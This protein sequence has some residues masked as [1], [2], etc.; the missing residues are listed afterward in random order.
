MYCKQE[1]RSIAR[2][3]VKLNAKKWAQDASDDK[4]REWKEAK[5]MCIV[6]DYFFFD[7]HWNAIECERGAMQEEDEPCTWNEKKNWKKNWTEES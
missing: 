7:A 3:C 5:S 1:A 2:N 4:G 6:Y